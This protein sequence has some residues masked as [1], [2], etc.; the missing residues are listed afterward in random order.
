MR[1]VRSSHSWCFPSG[2]AVFFHTVARKSRPDVQVKGSNPLTEHSSVLG[3]EVLCDAEGER[4]A[5]R[6]EALVE[7][8]SRYDAVVIAGQARSDCVART[9]DDLLQSL[10]QED[11]GLA[12]KVYLLEDCTSPLVIPGVMDYTDLADGAFR[13]FAEAGMHVVRS[14]DPISSWPGLS[15]RPR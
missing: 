10:Q 3:P 2:E 6:N 11:P 1:K 15:I 4:I 7:K 5:R 13:R 9:I 8:L 14:S 12:R